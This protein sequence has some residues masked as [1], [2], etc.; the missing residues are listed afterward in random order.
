MS[1]FDGVISGITKAANWMQENPAATNLFGG[2]LTG[3]GSYY[4]QKQANKDLMR[5]QEAQ[6][7]NMLE[8]QKELL[9]LQDK[10]KEKYSAVPDVDFGYGGLVVDDAPNL[11]NGGI[12]TEMKKRSDDK[13]KVM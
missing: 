7:K 2:I 12:L 10:M 1:Y 11:A 5:Q 13:K 3:V 6:Y 8:Y 9:G 4:A